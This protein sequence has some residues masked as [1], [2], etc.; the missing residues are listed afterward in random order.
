MCL[1]PSYLPIKKFHKYITVAPFCY[2]QIITYLFNETQYILT[3]QASARLQRWALTLSAYKY[4]IYYCPG[5]NQANADDLSKLP[6]GILDS[7]VFKRMPIPG[8]VLILME[9]LEEIQSTL[10]NYSGGLT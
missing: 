10:I 3:Q 4:L 2:V 9:H 8:D 1:R 6:T 7:Q 5:K